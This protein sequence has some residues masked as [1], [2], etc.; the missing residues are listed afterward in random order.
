MIKILIILLMSSFIYS[1]CPG[2][3][4]ND[5]TIN[6]Q[7]VVLLVNIVL[8]FSEFIPGSD[9]NGDGWVNVNDIVILVNYIL[10]N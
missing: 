9:I 5:Y 6:I 8:G 10:N 7:D 1:Q 3:L 2:D 4:N